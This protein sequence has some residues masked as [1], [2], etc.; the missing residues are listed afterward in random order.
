MAG[1]VIYPVAEATPFDSDTNDFTSEDCQNAIEEARD[2]APGQS[3]RYVL[4][5]GYDGNAYNNRWLELRHN[6]DMNR[7]PY[8]VAENSEIKAVS[9]ATRNKSTGELSII[10]N[11]TNIHTTTLNNVDKIVDGGLSYILSPGD[12][13]KVR[14]TSGSI[15]RPNH[16]I[17]I[18]VLS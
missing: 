8:I 13:V 12:E 4:I 7:N 1:V 5:S 18:K 17:S 10:V 6:N 11:G 15:S 16:Y 9:V 2:T 3:S 14:V